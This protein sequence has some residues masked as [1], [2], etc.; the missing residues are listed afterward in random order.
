MWFS[1]LALT[2]IT[3][4]FLESRP[5]HI[6]ITI[7]IFIIISIIIHISTSVQNLSDFCFTHKITVQWLRIKNRIERT[8]CQV[9][10]QTWQGVL[11]MGF[12][13]IIFEILK[14]IHFCLHK[15]IL[16]DHRSPSGFALF[17]FFIVCTFCTRMFRSFIFEAKVL[18]IRY[19]KI[20]RWIDWH[21]RTEW[22][23]R[24]DHEFDNT[25]TNKRHGDGNHQTTEVNGT[26][27]EYYEE[28]EASTLYRE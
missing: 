17:C 11:P 5:T 15:Y 23:T 1:P 16:S 24:N 8:P 12:L 6:T 22:T 4:F 18:Y 28:T 13:F 21:R 10:T 3:T 14:N 25:N 26:E 2:L 19:V 20:H 9:C 27:Y 7:I